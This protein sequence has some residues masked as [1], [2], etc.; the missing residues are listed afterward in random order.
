MKT[1]VR[2]MILVTSLTAGSLVATPVLTFNTAGASSGN[3]NDQSVG[4]E[5]N[6][7]APIT[8]TGLGWYD[9]NADGLQ[10]AHTVGIWN[11]SGTLLT[12]ALVAQ[13]TTDPLDGLFR[14]IAITPL[15]LAPG[16]GYIV[17]GQNFNANTEQLAF[18]VT[19]T[20]VSSISFVAGQ[21]SNI[22]GI[23]E[24]PTNPTGVPTCCWGPSFSIT[25]VPEPNAAALCGFGLVPLGLV[26]YR[27][28]TANR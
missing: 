23:F 2:L 14:T 24:R 26:M 10:L 17:G 4:W 22:D 3:E 12:S 11:S 19:P 6:V 21:F 13:G 8:V 1:Q 27:R 9:Q 25:G 7:L 28:R 20:T 15:I 16:T 18:G 5:F